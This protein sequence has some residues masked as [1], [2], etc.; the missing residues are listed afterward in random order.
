MK[1]DPKYPPAL[2][3]LGGSGFVLFLLYMAYWT[4]FYPGFFGDDAAFLIGAESLLN[5]SFKAIYLLGQPA[6]THFMPGFSILLAPFLLFLNFDNPLLRGVPLLATFAAPILM[7]CLYRPFLPRSIVVMSAALYAFHP[8]TAA[9]AS[10]FM[11]EPFYVA[12]TLTTFYVLHRTLQKETAALRWLLAL[13]CSWTMLTRPI[14]ILVWVAI[15]VALGITR[16]WR[17]L[18]ISAG[19]SLLAWGAFLL[20]NYAVSQSAND[21]LKFYRE[22]FR[23]L[24]NLG[25]LAMNGIRVLEQM[26]VGQLLNLD[27]WLSP[28]SGVGFFL[29]V[30]SLLLGILGFRI[31]YRQTKQHRALVVALGVFTVLHVLVHSV[32]LTFSERYALPALPFLSVCVIM[33]LATVVPLSKPSQRLVLAAVILLPGLLGKHVLAIRETLSS[34]RPP[35]SFAPRTTMAWVQQHIAPNATLCSRSP[36][37]LYLYTGRPSIG[38]PIARTA[39][40]AQTLLLTASVSLIVLQTGSVLSLSGNSRANQGAST[41]RFSNWVQSTPTIFRQI[42]ANPQEGTSIYQMKAPPV[43]P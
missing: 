8:A 4:R 27:F 6:Q 38:F 28:F 40:E 3:L 26:I 34:A 11:S 39:Q 35:E 32:W 30:G 21:Y 37:R 43:V 29:T 9:Y 20:R 42:Y 15:V 2:L 17:A 7:Y 13:G 31:L 18:G 16:R 10:T 1:A 33:G 22:Q 19:I 24:A 5:G 25:S 14:G 23:T 36:A 12:L 41:M